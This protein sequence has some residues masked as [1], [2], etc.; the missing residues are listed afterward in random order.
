MISDHIFKTSHALAIDINFKL[1]ENIGG[2]DA[3]LNSVMT[4]IGDITDILLNVAIVVGV[5]M[6]IYSAFLYVSSFGE[7][8]KAETAKKTLLWSIIGTI[9]VFLARVI[10]D[11]VG[12][13]LH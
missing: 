1:P 2:P 10:V 7:E 5:F 8:A 3:D 11:N 9:V 4:F 6:I 13:I 12:Q